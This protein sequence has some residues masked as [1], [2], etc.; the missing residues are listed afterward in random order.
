MRGALAAEASSGLC[1]WKSEGCMCEGVRSHAPCMR[2]LEPPA[3]ASLW[4]K[5]SY[6]WFIFA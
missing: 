3:S 5:R 6:V 1:V 2:V 4:S